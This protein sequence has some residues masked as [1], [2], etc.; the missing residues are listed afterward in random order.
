MQSNVHVRVFAADFLKLPFRT[1][2]RRDDER[3]A[4][5]RHTRG[6]DLLDVAVVGA[7]AASQYVQVRQPAF[8]LGVLGAEF[9]RVA[10]VEIG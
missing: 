3:L 9:G 6:G 5:Q 2:G 1:V 7:A 10:D 8:E 4:E